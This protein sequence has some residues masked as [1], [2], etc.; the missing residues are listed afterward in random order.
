[1]AY[2]SGPKKTGGL[3]L[4]LSGGGVRG[5]SH[6]GALR[7]MRDAGIRIEGV[8]GSSAGAYA[9]A[10]YAFDLPLEVEPLLRHVMDRKLASLFLQGGNRLLY[11]AKVQVR[12]FRAL[13]DPAI[14]DAQRLREG[15]LE[16]FGDVR[17]EEAPVPLALSA[18]DLNTGEV[19]VLREGPLVDAIL[20]SS[21]IP[22]IFP[23]VPWGGRLLVDGDIVEKV[24]V[25]AARSLGPAPVVG[26]DV[27]NPIRLHKPRNSFEVMLMA[28]EA[29]IRRLKELALERCDYTLSLVPEEQIDTFDYGQA[30]RVYQ[31][32]VER[33]EAAI[34]EL[35]ALAKGRSGGLWAWLKKVAQHC[36]S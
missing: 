24:P 25:S 27:S 21:A 9:A 4:A 7:V 29:S 10:S 17:I 1:M 2:F 15:L 36:K 18:S 20:A 26:V 22:G 32:G 14:D 30:R 8:A 31:L 16:Y 34:D 23:P 28:S 5:F 6:L 11:L 3:N 13:R 12:L 35:W 33:T 19:V